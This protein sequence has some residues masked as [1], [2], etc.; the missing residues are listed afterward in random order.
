MIK[1]EDFLPYCE[2]FVDFGGGDI[3]LA[4]DSQLVVDE[5]MRDWPE[6]VRSKIVRQQAVEGLSRN[7]TAAFELGVSKHKTNVEALTDALAMSK[8]TYLLHGLSALSEAAIYMN[9]GLIERSSNLED[10]DV[11]DE[12]QLKIFVNEV[13]PRGKNIAAEE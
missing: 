13:L 10:Y 1:V 6:R 5:I 7:E 11:S 8:C 12:R 4:T 3:F 9:P 2:A